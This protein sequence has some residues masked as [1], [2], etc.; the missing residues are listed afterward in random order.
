VTTSGSAHS[1]A[2]GAAAML[3]A[4][5]VLGTAALRAAPPAP[6]QAVTVLVRAL[7]A[8]GRPFADVR[9]EDVELKVDGRVRTPGSLQF[10]QPGSGQ[11]A[12]ARDEVPP[13]FATNPRACAADTIRRRGR[14]EGA[15]MA[16]RPDAAPAVRQPPCA[17]GS[18]RRAHPRGGVNVGL[19]TDRAKIQ[20]AIRN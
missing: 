8:D 9:L 1:F 20:S 3:V 5:G 15:S 11:T 18:R 19:T 12:S 13:P 17:P 10:V 16:S 7:L 14:V 6:P 2:A 4:A